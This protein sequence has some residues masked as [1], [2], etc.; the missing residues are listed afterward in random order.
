MSKW[1]AIELM[2][3]AREEPGDFINA[4]DTVGAVRFDGDDRWT[5][6]VENTT[7]P[8]ASGNALIAALLLLWE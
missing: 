1:L 4:F 7:E 2:N 8:L 3:H 6:R 5:L